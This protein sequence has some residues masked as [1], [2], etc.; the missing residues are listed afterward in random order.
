MMS[1]FIEYSRSFLGVPYVFGGNNRL[2][3][4][5]CS[6]FVCELLRS[7]G[8]VG[9]FEDLSAQ[10]LWLKQMPTYSLNRVPSVAGTLLFFGKSNSEITHVAL[11]LTELLM[12]EAGGG[13]HTTT[14]VGEAIKRSAM[15]RMRPIRFRQDYIGARRPIYPWENKTF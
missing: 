3:G 10:G 7:V 6:G 15:V 11:Q 8:V 12:I 4:L 14:T 2:T 9:A 1:E 13:D 5:D